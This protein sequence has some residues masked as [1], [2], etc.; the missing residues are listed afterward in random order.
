[1]K[2]ILSIANLM[3]Q[4]KRPLQKSK[5]EETPLAMELTGVGAEKC[6]KETNGMHR[7]YNACPRL[8]PLKKGTK[9][10]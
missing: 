1:M 8:P 4:R 2:D 5:R 3:A 6:G 10:N 7:I 9:A